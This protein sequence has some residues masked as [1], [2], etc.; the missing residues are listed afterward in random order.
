MAILILIYC[1]TTG[2]TEVL[3]E[4]V[5]TGL[6]K[7]GVDVTIKNVTG[8]GVNQLAD[9]DAIVLGCSTWYYGE[10]QD[11]FIDFYDKFNDMFPEGKKAAVFGPDI[12]TAISI[13]SARQWI[14]LRMRSKIAVF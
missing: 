12:V 11:D 4:H 6:K 8:V 3:A 5:A 7:A 9:F 1:S 10:L 2:N 13:H 14:F